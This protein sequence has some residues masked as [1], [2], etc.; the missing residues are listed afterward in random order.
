MR[1]FVVA[2]QRFVVHLRPEDVHAAL[3][4]AIP[5]EAVVAG[6]ANLVEWGNLRADPDT[7]RVTTVEDFRR[8]RF[9]Y[10]LTS[11]GEA[12]ERALNA[13][14]EHLGRRRSLQACRAD[15][16]EM[17]GSAADPEAAVDA[18]GRAAADRA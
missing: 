16:R 18:F 13:Y 9:L 4:D 17:S 3:T 11:R 15:R 12:V 1:T 7:S 8:A 6:L 5:Y 10:Q 2:K 14:D